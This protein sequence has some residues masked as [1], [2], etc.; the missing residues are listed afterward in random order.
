MTTDQAN[1]R[2][3]GPRALDAAL[4]AA[5]QR[6][7]DLFAA[8]V[9]AGHD[10]AARVPRLAIVNP[11]L[12]ELGHIAW[13]AEWF[14]LREAASSQPGDAVGH[15]LLGPG[16]DWFDS[17]AVAHGAR[18]TLGLPVP[19]L[20]KTY[21]RDVLEQVSQRLAHTPDDDAA[22]YPY[23]LALAH[24]DMHGEALLYTLQTL[25]VAPPTCDTADAEPVR[26]GVRRNRLRRRQLAAWRRPGARLRVR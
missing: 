7:L 11:P 19:D 4:H 21:C 26:P 22:L 17:N 23:R 9:V 6:T 10:Q 5:R 12:W 1:F 14:I 20:I 16:D 13:F 25:G 8:H 15:S 2:Q 18:W 24:E 3:M